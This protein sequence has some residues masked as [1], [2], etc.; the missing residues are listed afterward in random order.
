MTSPDLE[1]TRSETPTVVERPK[2]PYAAIQ[3]RV[4]MAEMGQVL[5][6]LNGQVLGWLRAQGASAATAPFWRYRMIDMATTLLIDVGVGTTELLD[7][8]HEVKTG[9]LPA[10]RY[11]TVRHT[12][13]P[14]SLLQATADLLDWAQSEGL[15]FDHCPTADGDAWGCRLEIY[16]TDPSEEPDLN[17]WVTDLAFR[18]ADRDQSRACE[19]V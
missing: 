4:T 1:E 18:L 8:D 3:R 7:S 11:A 14:D 17:V 16:Q 12:G 19:S 13:H 5:P 10:G 2:L 9:D 6:P 15:E